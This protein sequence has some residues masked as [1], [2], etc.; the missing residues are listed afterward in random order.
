MKNSHTLLRSTFAR[1]SFTIT[2]LLMLTFSL[3]S[4]TSCPP[5]SGLSAGWPQDRTVFYNVSSLPLALRTQ[6]INA[7][8]AWNTANS[9]NNSGVWFQAAGSTNPATFTFQV[10]PTTIPAKFDPIPINSS[11]PLASATVTINPNHPFFDPNAPG[12]TDALLKAFEHEIGHSMGLDEVGT[13]NPTGPCGGQSARVSIMNGICGVNDSANNMPKSIT[14]CDQSTIAQNSHYHRDPCPSPDC[15]E[16]SGFPVDMCSYPGTGGCPPGYHA[17][18]ACCQ[19]D[20]PTPILID[21]DGSGFH[22]TSAVEGVWYDFYG[23]GQ[24]IRLSW[25]AAG[26]TNSWLVL[27]SNNN[28]AIDS[29]LEMFGNITPQPFS[30][31]KNGF[32]ALA[33]Y[34]KSGAGGNEDGAITS[35]DTVFSGLRLWMDINHNGTTEPTELYTLPQLGIETL[36]LDY[37]QSKRT[38]EHGNQ[39]RYRAKVK[40]VHNAQPGRW[41]WDVV[42]VSAP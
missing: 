29:A 37:K 5:L 21:V 14:P 23:T 38:D 6:A 32:L 7:L 18:G 12:Y 11:Q 1:Y 28:G 27:D 26:S 24:K 3:R 39:F 40:D 4:Q 9:Q 19:P 35:Q 13:P 36:K 22:L 42:L 34:D 20:S 2:L 10:G 25:T 16:G 30:T 31:A 17:A 8:N 41:A 33:E 15:N